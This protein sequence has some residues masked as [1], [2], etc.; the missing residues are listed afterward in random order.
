MS[1]AFLDKNNQSDSYSGTDDQAQQK[2]DP[3]LQLKRLDNNI[4]NHGWNTASYSPAQMFAEEEEEK[5]AKNQNE[6]EDVQTKSEPGNPGTQTSMPDKV[7]QKMEGS[8]GQDFGDVSIHKD[9]G[10][11]KNMG[12]LAYTQ[13]K[14]IHFAPGQ[15]NPDSQ[16]GQELLGHELTHV[17]QQREGRVK[18]TPAQRKRKAEVK[19]KQQQA[20]ETSEMHTKSP[21]AQ[22]QL[23]LKYGT[24]QLKSEIARKQFNQYKKSKI[25]QFKRGSAG[26]RQFSS[27]TKQFER[28]LVQRKIAYG[29]EAYQQLIQAYFPDHNPPGMEL[30][31][32]REKVAGTINNDRGLENEADNMGKAAAQ[33]KFVNKQAAVQAKSAGGDKNHNQKTK[34][35]EEEKNPGD[36]VLLCNPQDN[37]VHCYVLEGD[38][39]K[40]GN[41][42]ENFSLAILTHKKAG[43]FYAVRLKT[44]TDSEQKV[45]YVHGSNLNYSIDE[46]IVKGQKKPGFGLIWRENMEPEDRKI[47]LKKNAGSDSGEKSKDDLK[48]HFAVLRNKP[49]SEL[50]GELL[51]FNTRVFVKET[52]ENGWSY[53]ELDDGRKGYIKS[54]AINRDMP[55]PGAKLYRI[56]SGEGLQNIIRDNY[57]DNVED[58]RFYANVLL[59][60]NNPENDKD[61]A[62][63][64]NESKKGLFSRVFDLTDYDGF[65]VKEGYWIW[66]PSQSYADSLLGKVKSGSRAKEVSEMIS[67]YSLKA[68]EILDQTIPV[69][70]GIFL[71]ASIGVT[72]GLPIGVGANGYTHIYRKD[73]DNLVLRK[74]CNI[75]AGLDTGVGAGFYIGGKGNFGA[76][77]EVG[78]NAEAK[79]DLYTD[80]QYEFPFKE[81]W[82]LASAI[83]A[84]NPSVPLKLGAII[85]M[86]LLDDK[87]SDIS[88]F[89]YI[90]KLKAAVGGKVQGSAVGEA[91]L[92]T[93]ST[94]KN[95]KEKYGKDNYKPDEHADKPGH[96][97]N[98][99]NVEAMALLKGSGHL[100]IDAE[101][102]ERDPK[103]RMPVR[104]TGNVFYD[105]GLEA[106]AGA[107]L[108]LLG[109][110]MQPGITYK[111]VFDFTREKGWKYKNISVAA[112]NGEMDFHRGAASEVELGLSGYE[113]KA[114]DEDKG[115]IEKTANKRLSKGIVEKD[116]I[117]ENAD[118]IT[119]YIQTIKFKKRFAVDLELLKGKAKMKEIEQFAK[120]LNKNKTQVKPG[121]SLG[122]YLTL[123]F[124]LEKVN[125][126]EVYRLALSSISKS[127][128]EE[129]LGG[130]QNFLHT[131]DIPDALK[132]LLS[133]LINEDTLVSAEWYSQAEVGGA[134]A[135][136]AALGAKVSFL[137][138]IGLGISF[139]RD[140]RN[141]ILQE[142]PEKQLMEFL[143][144]RMIAF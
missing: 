51:P 143:S 66:L 70:S 138:G 74:Y 25:K 5:Q 79:L 35:E 31:Q 82:A 17:V 92:R 72:F 86:E 119:K 38:N 81:D 126:K 113:E 78:A 22:M 131:G 58:Q 110:N 129:V 28:M 88:P 94:G 68:A 56:S 100:G 44:Q 134:V 16:K 91:G 59:E 6:E 52:T 2:V 89:S 55:D 130:I 75:D 142:K 40:P 99:L 105:T 10:K 24:K 123:E 90:K 73:Q 93:S 50:K 115:N 8:F 19:A 41:P 128:F 64:V 42:V 106:K 121:I 137:A 29:S 77:A 32:A 57:Q 85:F 116:T 43:D 69:G 7:Q 107:P 140:V 96:L 34:E 27:K 1:R 112:R 45:V 141:E 101:I 67:D 12:A 61:G 39:F 76:G 33:G 18:S 62:I 103:T 36:E 60:V 54:H 133:L 102:V 83:L 9:S 132:K 47:Y 97:M 3:E 136:K 37:F 124:D 65:V 108:N 4:N 49:E 21:E 26:R 13:G 80:L 117:F 30:S 111:L 127:K 135:G 15:Y 120:R 139:R 63:Y 53:V 95:Y 46:I 144:A 87:G 109:I 71:D 84:I 48:T 11:A 122:N 118:Q 125:Y 20:R 14:D 114:G 23:K 104:M 98:M